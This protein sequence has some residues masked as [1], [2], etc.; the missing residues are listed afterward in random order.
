MI[1]VREKLI[2]IEL[3]KSQVTNNGIILNELKIKEISQSMQLKDENNMTYNPFKNGL[4]VM[5]FSF[6]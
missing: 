3:K 4:Y 5:L 2:V 1:Y 6:F